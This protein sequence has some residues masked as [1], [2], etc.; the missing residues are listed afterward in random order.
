M[1]LARSACQ[2]MDLVPSAVGPLR[3]ARGGGGAR[4]KEVGSMEV[5]WRF[6]GYGAGL[7]FGFEPDL[8]QQ[9]FVDSPTL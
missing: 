4:G 7:D 9:S 3:V 2:Q 6:D 5:G 1:T 8:H